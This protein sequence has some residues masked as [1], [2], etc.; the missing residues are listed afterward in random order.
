MSTDPRTIQ[1]PTRVGTPLRDAA[2]DPAPG[3]FL[4]PVNAGLEGE[5]GNPHGPNVYAPGI[6]A[7]QGIRPVR[8]GAVS[9]DAAT[10]STEE[11]AHASQWQGVEDAPE[12]DP[13]PTDPEEGTP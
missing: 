3:D 10:Q 1:N 9:A 2:V 7:E 13:E 6:H 11:S 5:E 12:P 8:P 4:P